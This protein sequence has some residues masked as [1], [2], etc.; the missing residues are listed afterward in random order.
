MCPVIGNHLWKYLFQVLHCFVL[1]PQIMLK[2]DLSFLFNSCTKSNKQASFH[3]V[4]YTSLLVM[5]S[6]SLISCICKLHRKNLSRS[7]IGKDM[8]IHIFF[9]VNWENHS[10]RFENLVSHIW[11]L[12]RLSNSINLELPAFSHTIFVT[13]EFTHPVVLELLGFLLYMKYLGTS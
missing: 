10:Y 5:I 3:T 8:G 4:N 9:S 13:W 11:E 7:I 6:G 1:P 2:L 12:C